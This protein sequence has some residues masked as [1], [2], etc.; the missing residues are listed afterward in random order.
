MAPRPLQ[1]VVDA[2]Y[3]GAKASQ[4]FDSKREHSYVAKVLRS[5]LDVLKFPHPKSDD[6]HRKAGG[7]LEFSWRTT[8]NS[9]LYQAVQNAMALT[10]TAKGLQVMHEHSIATVLLRT[11][12]SRPLPSPSTRGP[13]LAAVSE[14]HTGTKALSGM[15]SP[16]SSLPNPPVVAF[17]DKVSE[18]RKAQERVS[19]LETR[20]MEEQEIRDHLA[21]E[22]RLRDRQWREQLEENQSLRNR[23]HE[24]ELAL[25]EEKR[26]NA[27]LRDQL[28]DGVREATEE[29]TQRVLAESALADIRRECREPFV[30]PA[31]FDAFLS[32]SKLTSSDP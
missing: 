9:P 29:R 4:L 21:A 1:L 28:A 11:V 16:P 31:L 7:I 23:L 2:R 30:V 27:R 13:P 14:S 20:L 15:T 17:E 10:E 26:T 5:D 25:E 3:F 24:V 19:E 18:Y 6:I 8:K 22:G 12:Q 32:L